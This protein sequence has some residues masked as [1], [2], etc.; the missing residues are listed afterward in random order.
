MSEMRLL[1]WGYVLEIECLPRVH[2]AL[3]SK[4]FHIRACMCTRLRAL[5]ISYLFSTPNNFCFMRKLY[6]NA[7]TWLV[8]SIYFINI[9]PAMLVHFCNPS[10]Q[11]QGEEGQLDCVTRPALG[12]ITLQCI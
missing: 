6:K 10:T 1:G 11:E 2:E 7:S 5:S 8:F 3:G 4:P 12:S 9:L